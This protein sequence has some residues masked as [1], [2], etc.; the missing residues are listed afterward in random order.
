MTDAVHEYG[1]EKICQKFGNQAMEKSGY[2][3]EYFPF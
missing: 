1:T 3:P 2:N